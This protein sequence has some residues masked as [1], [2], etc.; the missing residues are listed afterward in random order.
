MRLKDKVAIIT[1]SGRGLGKLYAERF[2]R[3][4]A[5]ITV[6]DVIDCGETV[7]EIESIGGEVLS[8]RTDVTSEEDTAEMARKTAE[9]F[10]RIDILVTNAAI[11]GGLS[12]KPFYEFTVDEWDKLMAVNLKGM[13]LSCKAVFSYMKAQGK[14]KIVTIS[15]GVH[16]RGLPYFIHYTTSKGGVVAFTRAMAQELGQ[17]HINVNSVAPGLILTKASTDMFSTES[18]KA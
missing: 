18:I 3:E 4:G 10:G 14:G 5:K 7:K 8:L 9:R 15:S 13:W 16:F 6:C 1:G 11:Y 2:A 17:Y 12:L